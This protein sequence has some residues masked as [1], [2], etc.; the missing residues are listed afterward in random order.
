MAYTVKQLANMSN[1][2]VRTL[3]WYDEKGL[4]K[5]A[6]YGDNG[7]RYY[8]E[9]ELLLLQQILFFKE[10]GFNLSDIQKLLVQNDFDNV[11]AL[12]THKQSLLNEVN[13][14]NDLIATIDKTLSHLRGK[15]IM[16]HKELY[17]GFDPVKQKE[18]EQYL[19]GEYGAHAD[20]LLKQSHQRTA[21]WNKDQWDGVKSAIDAIHTD[22]ANAIDSGLTPDSHEVQNIVARHF[23]LQNRFYDVTKEVY[24][25]LAD[26]YAQHPDFRKVLIKY[27]PEMIEYLG[28]AISYYVDNNL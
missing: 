13:R 14:K 8:A 20:K 4:L 9:K 16:E 24:L 19:E 23:E 10:L 22:L 18:Y 25:G 5:P 28:Q 6:Y 1:V 26:L 7:Y 3:H 11:K 17:A 27:H 15:Q 21:K 12:E 2:S